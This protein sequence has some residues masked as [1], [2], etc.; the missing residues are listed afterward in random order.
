MSDPRAV[1]RLGVAPLLLLG[2]NLHSGDL[3]PYLGAML[4]VTLLSPGGARP[5][6]RLLAGM[7][8]LVAGISWGLSRGFGAL[9][10]SPASVWMALL[11]LATACFAALAVKPQNMPALL[12]LLVA[13]VVTALIQAD[14]SLTGPLPWLMAKAVLQAVL[15]TLLAH[16]ALPSRGAG[17]APP[18]IRAA[19][20]APGLRALAK[21]C[22]MVA[23][24]ALCAA[25]GQ[26]AGVLV[27]ITLSNMLRLPED[28]A[29]RSFGRSL[30]LANL[31]AALLAVPV[32]LVA[33]LRPDDLAL[34]P[35]ALALGLWI[36]AGHGMPGWRGMLTQL[37][38][39]VFVLLLGQ[40]LPQAGAGAADAL[41]D[42]LVFLGISVAA[43]AA[44][45]V[46]LAP[47]RRPA[48]A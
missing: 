43:G 15:V 11:A 19:P 39:P 1:F 13:V 17:L 21:A 35:L 14:P 22:A 25:A 44:V 33:M 38:L 4:A 27:A 20:E 5:P 12:A 26:A 9:S 45:L 41:L 48:R 7:I 10:D 37:G 42:R 23:A 40:L 16:A 47:A 3:L 6:M 29:A 30:V 18:A 31:G 24:L 28:A 8:L 36:A 32:L 34:I 46:L 2:W